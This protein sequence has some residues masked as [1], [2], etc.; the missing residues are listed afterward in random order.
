MAQHELAGPDD[1]VLTEDDFPPLT[2]EELV[3]QALDADPHVVVA[4]DVLPLYDLDQRG[5][6]LP[7]WYM[8]TAVAHSRRHSKKA[9]VALII[10]ALLLV[11]A[12]GFCITYGALTIA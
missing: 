12:S 2:E 3:R 11:V 9:L 10:A 1:I 5:G 8:P 7:G 4:D 6:L